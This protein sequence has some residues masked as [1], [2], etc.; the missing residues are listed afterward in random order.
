[1]AL[2]SRL[3][4]GLMVTQ[5][6]RICGKCALFGRGSAGLILASMLCSCTKVENVQLG[7]ES[8]PFG[9]FGPPRAL[10]ELG[11]PSQNPTLTGDLLE[12]YITSNR[13]GSLSNN[14][15]TWVAKRASVEE[16]FGEP[17]L[18][19]NVNSTSEESSPAISVDGLTLWFASNR[20]GGAGGMDIWVSTRPDKNSDWID[21]TPVTA[22]NTAGYEIPRPVGNH[23]LQMPMSYHGSSGN[24]Q[25]LM[26]TRPSIN[27]DWMAPKLITELAD[28][29]VLL[30]D[31]FLTDAGTMLLFNAEQPDGT[32]SDIKRTWR[33]TSNDQFAPPVLVDGSLNSTALNR[34]PWLSPDGNHFFF[35][36]DRDGSIMVYEAD[37][38]R[39]Q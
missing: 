38:D 9:P 30:V 32:H 27:A 23:G 1:M 39:D 4:Q 33:L 24:Y 34:D 10:T 8:P 5:S 29:S 13:A 16:A 6:P 28:S 18:V 15:D 20:S 2:E 25:L 14:N 35:S 37:A 12:I 36:S 11:T 21:P 22:L 31:G 19:P 3:Q 26:A 7:R 17:E